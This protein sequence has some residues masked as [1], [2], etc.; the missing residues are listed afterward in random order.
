MSEMERR[1]GERVDASLNLKLHI[2]VG[3]DGS[4]E[5]LETLNISSSGV[6]F[7][8]PR[9]VEPMTKLGLSLDVPTAEGPAPV[10]CEGIVARVN[11]D[12]PGEDVDEYEVA[13]FFTTI[14]ADSLHNLE[15][16]VASL[17]TA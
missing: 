8:C 6:Y 4:A 16:Y 2:D 14:D 7:R 3:E 1:K 15:R 13:V 10:E 9:F 12:V 5:A 17:L 11:P